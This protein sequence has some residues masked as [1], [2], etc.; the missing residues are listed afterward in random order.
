M[1]ENIA[2][3]SSGKINQPIGI[4]RI[5]G[6][7]AFEIVNKVFRGKIGNKHEITFGRIFD[8]DLLLDEVLVGWF[9]GKDN[10]LG[11]DLVEIY[12]HGGVIVTES[13]LSVLLA[14]G[15]RLAEPGEFSKIA[16]L[17]GKID[18][19]KAEA[20][21]DLIF[22][23]TKKQAELSVNRF[24]GEA[25]EEIQKL[26]NSVAYLIGLCEVNIDYPEY[27]DIE[28][29]DKPKLLKELNKLQAKIIKIIENTERSQL[30]FG[31]LK[32]VI[33]GKPNVGKSSLLNAL[34]KENKAIV[35]NIPGTTRDVVEG[36]MVIN[37]IV[38]KLL[39]TA[40]VRQTNE[41]IEKI[42][43]Q[44]TFENIAT[45]DVVVHVLDDKPQD[46]FD[47]KIGEASK[48]KIYIVLQNKKDLLETS[49]CAKSLCISAINNDIESLI[50]KLSGL[51]PR[52]SAQDYPLTLNNSRQM[53]LIKEALK[54]TKES[55]ASV[56]Q[57]FDF[58][59]VVTDLRA[60]W[61]NLQ[62]IVGKACED[63]L[64]TSIFSNFCLGK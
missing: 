55:I 54:Y 22:A 11:Q 51:A 49:A 59:V 41:F 14:N 42:G 44:K 2:A 31:G 4:I 47:A 7:D 36:E 29:V 43:V 46:I 38:F 53:G 45:S 10:F 26:I 19:I 52:L 30:F 32:M 35:T 21:H 34:L 37:N 23:K 24:N 12:S 50:E 9:K 25:S 61:N 8:V 3:I 5:T 18:L 60:I 57:G 48:S 33:V 63:D 1:L 64:L 17:N 6:P 56:N 28:R 40:G 20:I 16:F 27:E 13:I 39:D 62:N 15:A 58:E